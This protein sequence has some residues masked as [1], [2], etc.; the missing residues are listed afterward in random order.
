MRGGR[1][2]FGPLYRRDRQLKQRREECSS[3]R[4]K[5][6]ALPTQPSSLSHDLQPLPSPT[7][8]PH[9][10]DSFHQLQPAACGVGQSDGFMLLD[11]SFNRDRAAVPPTLPYAGLYHSNYQSCAQ[12]QSFSHTLPLDTPP[13]LPAAQPTPCLLTELLQGEPEETQLCARVLASLQREQASRGKHDCLNTFSIMC[14]MADH[15]LFALVE[16]ARSST[17][18]K[19]LKVNTDKHT[20]IHRLRYRR[21]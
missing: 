10:P 6:E 15:T 19:E 3:Y 1:N 9:T 2:K 4:V 20:H 18:F 11:C 8:S 7:L 14:K 17:L 13:V 12:S 21:K 5:L 16:W